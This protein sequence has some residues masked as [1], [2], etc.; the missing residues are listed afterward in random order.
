MLHNAYKQNINSVS[1]NRTS[2]SQVSDPKKKIQPQKPTSNNPLFRLT[3][4]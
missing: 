1:T 3:N 2:R 4:N